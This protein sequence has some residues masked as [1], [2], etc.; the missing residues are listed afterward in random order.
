[1]RRLIIVLLLLAGAVCSAQTPLYRGRTMVEYNFPFNGHFYWFDPEFRPGTVFFN[2]EIH[3]NV[4]I[5]IN[6]HTGDLLAREST[7]A[8][9][10]VVPRELTPWFELNGIRYVNLRYCG[11][12]E[13]PEGYFEVLRD[14]RETVY[15]QRVKM[16][17]REPGNHNGPHGIGYD[18]PNYREKVIAYFHLRDNYY[19]E[20]NGR[21]KKIHPGRRRISRLQPVSEPFADAEAPYASR[22]QEVKALRA[23]GAR[24]ELPPEWFS[25]GEISSSRR[26]LLDAIE[27]ENLIANYRNKTY[28]IGRTGSSKGPVTV[29]GTVRDVATG[30]ELPS[31]LVTDNSGRIYCY[32]DDKGVYSLKLPLGENLLCFRETT[33][34]DMDI[35]VIIRGEGGLDVVMREKVT[36][37]KSAYVTANS[38]AE[39]RRAGMGLETINSNLVSHIPSA[40]GE[41]DVIKAVL[42]LPGV[43]SVGEASSGFNVRGGSSDQN[44]ILLNGGTIYNPS[45][46][47]G[48]FS[49]FN[50][51]V[52]DEVELYKSSI[53][54]Q[55][56]GRISSV[57][58]I[59]T[60]DGSTDRIHGSLGLG[61]LTSHATIEG[62]IVKD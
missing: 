44:L 45:H 55:Y 18:D 3:E 61:I 43:K 23:P 60:R 57:L 62:P 42:T 59:T 47:F 26:A 8:A 9:P 5:N 16:F 38:M 33:K 37:L 19:A 53:P 2:G 54:V 12:P 49:A 30:E 48:V 22:A 34:E 28:E 11:I 32:T 7:F 36:A 46:L 58:D 20:R 29:T 56:G 13:A 17:A 4:M 14:Q 52:L 51:D 31:V 24:A 50:N 10:V 21:F 35:H 6:A 27:Q 25:T 40:F 15:Q 1:M 41:G 39:H